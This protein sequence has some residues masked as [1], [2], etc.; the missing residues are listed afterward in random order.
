LLGTLGLHGA[1]VM[2]VCGRAAWKGGCRQNCLPHIIRRLT[3]SNKGSVALN[4][5]E[6][7]LLEIAARSLLDYLEQF[8]CRSS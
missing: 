5:A 6:P 2:F 7:L 3:V 1:I 4:L 8:L